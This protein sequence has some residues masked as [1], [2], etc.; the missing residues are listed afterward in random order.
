R[1]QDEPRGASSARGAGNSSAHDSS[2]R[3]RSTSFVL[4]AG[5]RDLGAG[6]ADDYSPRAA[7]FRVSLAPV[8]RVRA[9]AARPILDNLAVEPVANPREPSVNGTTGAGNRCVWGQLSSLLS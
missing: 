3:L 9:R 8:V 7:V 1:R 5:S 4:D 6:R 2:F